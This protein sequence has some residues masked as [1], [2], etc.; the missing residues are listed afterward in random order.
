VQ[1]VEQVSFSGDLARSEN[2]EV[3][4]VTERAVFRLAADGVELVEVAPGIDIERDVLSQMDFRPLI[5][6]VKTMRTDDWL[7]VV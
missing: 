3:L 6:Q 5:R 7:Q 2:R 1:N 4:Y